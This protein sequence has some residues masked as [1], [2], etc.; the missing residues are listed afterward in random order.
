VI[1]EA[2]CGVGN[3][4][5]PVLADN[6]NP[7]LKIHGRDYSP[8]AIEVLKTDPQFNSQY[9]TADVWDMAS[10]ELP[11]GIEEESV[12]VI[13]L[14]FVLSAL[15]CLHDTWTKFKEPRQWKQAISNLHRL[16]KPGGLICFRDYGRYDMTQL[17]FKKER[18]LDDNFYIRGDGTRVYFFEEST[19]YWSLLMA[20]ELEEIFSDFAIDQLVVDRRLLVNRQ[21]L[22]KM[23]RVW[24]QGRFRKLRPG[25]EKSVPQRSVR[26]SDSGEE[27]DS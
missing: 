5:F 8:R 1:F 4:M 19:A 10:E 2:G 9:A 12:D 23:Y 13:T 14:L 16:L 20:D 7:L 3:A 22:K 25:E 26:N 24:F 21:N 15:V 11:A 17:R 6:E 27:I 18:L